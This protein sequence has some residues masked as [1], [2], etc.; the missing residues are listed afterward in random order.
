VQINTLV[1]QMPYKSAEAVAVKILL[2]GEEDDGIEGVYQCPRCGTK[3]VCAAG[4]TDNRDF[5]KDIPILNLDGNT[6]FAVDISP[7]V[8]VDNVDGESIES[9]A[10]LEFDHPTMAHC[11]SAFGRYGEK[12]TVK[13]QLGIYLEALVSVNGLPA[14]RK[15]KSRYGLQ[16]MRDIGVSKIK[17]IGVAVS[18][19]GMQTEAVKNCTSC[20]KEFTVTLNTSSFF[21]SALGAI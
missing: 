14:D 7:A 9:V 19:Y 3:K 15:W 20:G 16:V 1:G 12:D 8:H 10:R 21:V 2:L 4:D 5:I 13:L 17:E 6:R 11:I 18:R